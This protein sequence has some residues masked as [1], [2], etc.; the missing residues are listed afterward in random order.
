MTMNCESSTIEVPAIGVKPL[1]NWR[2]Y[3]KRLWVARN[4]VPHPYNLSRNVDMD[5]GN[6][7]KS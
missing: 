5:D 3:K 1:P 6:T 7:A 4:C 2:K